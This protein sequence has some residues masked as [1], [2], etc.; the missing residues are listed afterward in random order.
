MVDK[1]AT[2]GPRS[3]PNA[4]QVLGWA[5]ALWP[6]VQASLRLTADLSEPVPEHTEDRDYFTCFDGQ[7]RRMTIRIEAGPLPFDPLSEKVRS[8]RVHVNSTSDNHVIQ[9]SDQLE[10]HEVGLELAYAASELVA[11]RRR[12]D[13]A[14][15]PVRTDLISTAAVHLEDPRRRMLSDR[16][17]SRVAELDWRAHQ[18]SNP[19][20]PPEERRKARDAFS[21]TLDDLRLRIVT[22]ERHGRVYRSQADAATFRFLAI[23]PSMGRQAMGYIRELNRPLEQLAPDDAVA[24][25]AHRANVEAI[26]NAPDRDPQL[27]AARRQLDGPLAQATAGSRL[28]TAAQQAAE[29]RDE[30]SAKTL[31]GIRDAS[32]GAPIGAVPRCKVM[33]G[34]GA[35][36]TGREAD[37]L[38]ID[39]RG[40]WHI[41]PIRGIVQSADQVR[42][43]YDSGIGDP[44]EWAAPRDRVPLGALQL[45]EDTAA[46]RGPVVDGLANLTVD[47]NGRLVADIEPMDGSTPIRVEVEGTPVVATGVAPE[48]TPGASR[49]VPTVPEA[50]AV[51]RTQLA[52]DRSGPAM[53]ALDAITRMPGSHQDAPDALTLLERAGLDHGDQQFAEAM[54]TLRAT[55]E[56]D[57][58]RQDAPDR[59]LYGDEV[60]N[61]VYDPRAGNTWLLAGIGGAASANAEIILEANPDATV[62]MVGTEAPWVLQ[63]DAQYL[64]LR[65]LHDRSVNPDATGRIV[66]VPNRRLGMVATVPGP[67]G[68]PVVQMMDDKGGE[69]RTD[70]GT[71]VRGDVYVACLGRVARMPPALEGLDAWAKQV[72]GEL[73]FNV[74]RQYLGY[75]LTFRND[76]VQHDVEVTGA[77][78]WLLP[79][80][81]F[82]GAE[83]QRVY[84]AGERD[85]PRESGNAPAGFMVAALQGRMFAEAKT[86]A[87]RLSGPSHDDKDLAEL[88][89]VAGVDGPGP[90]ASGSRSAATASTHRLQQSSRGLHRS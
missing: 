64:P 8:F 49:R 68:R 89:R 44:Y 29:T 17:L 72:D 74:D 6:E 55:A 88:R 78:S 46:I 11:V 25:R 19:A 87:G 43:I 62:V 12:A 73:M 9:L 31:A 14:L 21:A 61:N 38:L 85:A 50:L 80:N 76:D 58:A 56:W 59:I 33:I 60:A 47:A 40:R 45:W 30:L 7:G 10:D 63:N 26:R 54:T 86:L 28:A 71:P 15:P 32:D 20:L 77:A 51:V 35:A 69:V 90:A 13:V 4:E 36:L 3:A 53:E 48:I 67:D 75:R 23:E 39:G 83:V 22:D 1:A 16:E 70:D 66:T 84:E 82:D 37:A 42:H 2:Y 52:A 5:V 65:R 27:A 81:V 24:L 18:M 41:D 34:G 79:A 57:R